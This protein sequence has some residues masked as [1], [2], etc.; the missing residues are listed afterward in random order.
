MA[1]VGE[2]RHSARLLFC[3]AQPQHSALSSSFV[4]HVRNDKCL[5]ILSFH[6]PFRG[7]I[8]ILPLGS[9]ARHNMNSIHAVFIKRASTKTFTA[10]FTRTIEEV[11]PVLK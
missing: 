7:L 9:V 5:T 2:S 3:S 1:M 6:R 10:L 8:L 4:C 11:T